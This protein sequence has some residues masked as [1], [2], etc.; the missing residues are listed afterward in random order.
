MK[1]NNKGFTLAEMLIV[2]AIIG[3]LVAI[4]I[5]TFTSQLEKSKEATDVANMRSAYSEAVTKH[6][7]DS[8]E[9]DTV[10]IEDINLTSDGTFD[11]VDTDKLPFSM[12]AGFSVS[13]GLYDITFDFSGDT[14]AA[15]FASA[16]E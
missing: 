12:P 16:G 11:Y 10:T 4:A 5:P 14:P 1:N 2:I 3:V 9:E 6:L 8:P 15:T 13:A 7:M